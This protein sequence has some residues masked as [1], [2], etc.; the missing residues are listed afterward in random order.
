MPTSRERELQAVIATLRASEARYRS[1]F[2]SIDTGYGLIDTIE[3][4]GGLWQFG[5][6]GAAV[7]SNQY[8]A[9]PSLHF[10]WSMWCA[11]TMIWVI[12]RGRRRHLWLLYPLATL[13][14]IIV[15]ANLPKMPKNVTNRRCGIFIIACWNYIA[16]IRLCTKVISQKSSR[17]KTIRFTPSYAKKRTNEFL[18][19]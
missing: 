3:R 1:L 8:A 2:Q 15:T 13:F 7:V 14:C 18:W 5:E 19:C 10:G 16:T 17:I 11:L 9:M 4:W 12:G 6:G